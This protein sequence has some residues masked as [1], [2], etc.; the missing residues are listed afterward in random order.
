MR[1][2]VISDMH[3]NLISLEA[4]LA[5]IRESGVDQIIC[6]GDCVQGGPQPAQVVARLREL[7][8]PI[9][10]GNADSFLLTGEDTEAEPTDPARWEKLLTVR[11]WSLSQL[12]SEDRAFMA[13]FQPTVEVPLDETRKLIGFHGSPRSFDEIILPET[14][15]AEAQRMLGGFEPHF[16]CGG[17]TH[18]QQIRHLGAAFYFGCGSTSL[19]FRYNHGGAPKVNP[20]AEFAIF[21]VDKRQRVSLDFRHVPFDIDELSDIYR[22]SGRPYADEVLERYS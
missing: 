1:I 3:G 22:A 6:L 19:P 15:D 17:H 13:G 12:S 14:P 4:V 10:M 5:E 16:L 9:V 7:A 20:W 21:T 18:I 8:C 11:A 2:A